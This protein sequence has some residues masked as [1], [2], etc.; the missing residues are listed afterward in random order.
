MKI[1]E[2]CIKTFGNKSKAIALTVGVGLGVAAIVSAVI[3]K[4][5]F[6]KLVKVKKEEKA[7]ETNKTDISEVKL[8]KAEYAKCG[9]K[10]FGKTAG[11]ALASFC[12]LLVA[13]AIGKEQVAI[14]SAYAAGIGKNKKEFTDKV[15]EKIGEKKFE[16]IQNSIE[17]DRIT[18]NPP[19]AEN[20]IK[21]GHGGDIFYDM[22][23]DRYFESDMNTVR[24]GVINANNAYQTLHSISM[25]DFYYHV[26]HRLGNTGKGQT[27]G[28]RQGSPFCKD[29]INVQYSSKL[30]TSGPYKDHAVIIMR[31]AEDSEP[32]TNLNLIA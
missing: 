14:A 20:V 4:D 3:E 11:I 12:F 1:A 25:D 15:K 5:N 13:D 24:E 18:Q 32:V 9:V 29:K 10:T 19:T 23:N 28:W 30:C 8:T 7:K 31:F 27:F 21:S 26:N 2:F 17:D 6:D 22:W 16:E